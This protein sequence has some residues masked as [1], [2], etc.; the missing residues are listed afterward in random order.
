MFEYILTFSVPIFSFLSYS[1]LSCV[2]PKFIFKNKFYETLFF[3]FLYFF[4]LKITN[5][6]F[7]FFNFKKIIFLFL[8]SI[9]LISDLIEKSLYNIVSYLFGFFGFIFLFFEKNFLNFYDCFY[10]FL[11][12]FFIFYLFHFFTKKIYKKEVFGMGDVIFIPFLGLYFGHK[13][14]IYSIFSA[15]LMGSLYGLTL[16]FLSKKKEEQLMLPF[17]P[18]IFLGL[19]FSIFLELIIY[20]K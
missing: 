15:S 10:T 2:S 5:N 4:F 17:I 1:I 20:I 11:V 16:K 8:F 3:L 12:S 18:F 13:I 6:F 19:S 9:H 7:I 14:L